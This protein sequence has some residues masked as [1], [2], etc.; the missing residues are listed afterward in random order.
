MQNFQDNRIFFLN[1]RVK[2]NYMVLILKC[3]ML[4]EQTLQN[5]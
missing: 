2:K 4:F 1:R 3:V 5:A